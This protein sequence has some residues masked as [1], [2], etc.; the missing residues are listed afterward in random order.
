MKMK[1]IATA[2]FLPAAITGVGLSSLGAAEAATGHVGSHIQAQLTGQHRHQR[3]AHGKAHMWVSVRPGDTLS[4][5][6]AAHRMSWQAIYATPP[7]FRHLASPDLLTV[8][9]RVRIPSSPKRREAEFAARFAAMQPRVPV[10]TQQP[11]ATQSPT[12]PAQGSQS[13]TG[14]DQTGTGQVPASQVPASQAP[15]A[16][17][18][19]V[20]QTAPSGGTSSFQQCVALH[21][22]GNNPTAS[23]SGLYGILPSTWSSLGFSGTAGQASVAQQNAAFGKLY[24]QQGTQPWAP[25]DG[26]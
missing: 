18:P 19:A 13:P 4:R 11:S 15:A 14:T 23:S 10:A 24:G 22:S 16:Q 21:E 1:K 8:G 2:T 7:N 5:I 3:A 26:C 9:Q 17:A 12:G 20:T 6:A 25:Y